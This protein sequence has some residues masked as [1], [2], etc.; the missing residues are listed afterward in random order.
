MCVC[1]MGGKG[2][3]SVFVCLCCSWDALFFKH[4]SS[5]LPRAPQ[6]IRG[7]SIVIMEALDRVS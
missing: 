6:V 7:N 4:C 2:T 1:T 5:L 3:V